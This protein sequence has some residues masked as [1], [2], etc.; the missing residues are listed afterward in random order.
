LGAAVAITAE[1]PEAVKARYQ[2]NFP[3]YAAVMT[4]NQHRNDCILQAGN[5]LSAVRN[6]FVQS[7]AQVCDLADALRR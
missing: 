1:P 6:D 7:A 2:T 5:R 3:T 4:G